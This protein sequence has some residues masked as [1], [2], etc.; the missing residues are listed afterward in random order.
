MLRL[1]K[2]TDKVLS[3]LLTMAFCFSVKVNAQEI[4]SFNVRDIIAGDINDIQVEAVGSDLNN[5]GLILR[6]TSSRTDTFDI[7]VPAGTL[8]RLSD[9]TRAQSK[10]LNSGIQDFFMVLDDR[11]RIPGGGRS[12]PFPK[13]VSGS[14]TEDVL[15][16][17]LCFDV[18]LPPPAPSQSFNPSV[19]S[20]E[21]LSRVAQMLK[22]FESFEMKMKLIDT[23]IQAGQTLT[24]DETQRAAFIDWVEE[25]GGTS[26]TFELKGG[27]LLPGKSQQFV[28][29]SKKS[30]LRISQTVV[31]E[32]SRFIAQNV[33]WTIAPEQE[34]FSS[35]GIRNDIDHALEIGDTERLDQ[36]IHLTNIFLRLLGL[37]RRL[38]VVDSLSVPISHDISFPPFFV[39]SWSGSGAGWANR[40]TPPNPSNNICSWQIREISYFI[41]SQNS[42]SFDAEIL[43]SNN[44]SPGSSLMNRRTIS[45]PALPD[46]DVVNV[47]VENENIIVDNDF[48]IA[49]FQNQASIPNVLISQAINGRAH[50]FNGVNWG[51][52]GLTLF[53]RA[54]LKAIENQVASPP[55]LLAPA[56]GESIPTDQA[57][58]VW[59]KAVDPNP[60]DE[61]GYEIEFSLESD[62]TNILHTETDLGDTTFAFSSLSQT[63]RDQMEGNLVYWHVRA[64]DNCGAISQ[65]SHHFS[66]FTADEV[67]THVSL[68]HIS[69]KQFALRQNYPNPFNPT[70]TIQFELPRA[71]HVSIAIYNLIGQKVITLVNRRF[72]AG[73]HK[74]NWNG[75][76]GN[77]SPLSS[78]VYL[79]RMEA[80]EFNE[81]KKLTLIQ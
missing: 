68:D 31:P 72:D 7:D 76:A 5:L 2:P 71:R 38:L 20:L 48:F 47:D 49:L 9:G 29:F 74:V 54:T 18:T 53:F 1:K 67:L 3:I 77:D 52:E 64:E 79:M 27:S 40:M 43:S 65:F 13:G 50:G 41:Q 42:G 60:E 62:F 6:I 61:L 57:I 80:E 24:D 36:I 63:I 19:D 45:F 32:I 23:K 73:L 46:G 75:R 21:S 37:E 34:N 56:S 35:E 25:A 28:L 69:P 39:T 11:R 33:V 66:F 55:N 59:S 70:T 81:V 44:G 15:V 12:I 14:V 30:N 58:F 17:A 51:R 8:F 78:G 4:P 16:Y 22:S 26:Q 10:Y